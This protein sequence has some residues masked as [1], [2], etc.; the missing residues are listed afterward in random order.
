MKDLLNYCMHRFIFTESNI[1]YYN[2]ESYV[3]CESLR[4]AE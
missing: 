2:S 1:S 3:S 4:K